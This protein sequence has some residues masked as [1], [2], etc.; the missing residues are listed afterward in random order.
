MAVIKPFRGVRYNPAKVDAI[1]AVVSQPYDKIDARFQEKYYELSPYNIVRIILGK[2]E[3][4]DQPASPEGPNVY[5]RAHTC[6]REWIKSGVLRREEQPALYV[7]EQTFNV[8]GKVYARLGMT[9][10]VEL[11]D[12]DKGVILPHEKTHSGPQEDRL[13]L[14]KTMQVNTEQIFILYPDAENKINALLRRAI[15]NQDPVLDLVEIFESDVQQRVWAITDPA[16]LKQVEE[17]MGKIRG[18]IIADGHHR[19]KTGLTYRDEQRAAYPDAPANA[20]FNFVQATL[21]SMTDPGLVVLPTHREICNFTATAPATILERA[22]AHFAIEKVADLQT[23]LAKVNAHPTGHAFGFFAAGTGF[24][25][26]TLKNDALADKLIADDHSPEWKAL[27][28]SVLHK[29]LLEQIAGVP[30]Q[31]IDDKSMI[32]YHRDPQQPVENIKQGKGNFVFFVAATRMDQIKEIAGHGEIMP[33]K[34]T[35]FYPKMIS[36]LTMLP[37]APDERL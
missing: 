5:T 29:I 31:G 13:R 10:A 28:V 23:C 20:A 36:G 32:R 16:I 27:S 25:V 12:F 37:L 35:D 18:L 22:Q 14:L 21:V 7:Y 26:L 11:V 8:E 2:S 1:Q 15:G 33:Q 3:M 24:Q 34:S 30:V 4:G 6:Y 17:E 9:S 19:Y